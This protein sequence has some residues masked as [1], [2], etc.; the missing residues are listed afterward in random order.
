[1]SGSTTFGE[2]LSLGISNG[3]CSPTFCDTHE[4]P[5]MVDLEK[6]QWDDGNDPCLIA[7]RLGNESEWQQDAEAYQQITTTTRETK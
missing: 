5:P 4:G 6:Q 7:V 3:W 1:M 2:W